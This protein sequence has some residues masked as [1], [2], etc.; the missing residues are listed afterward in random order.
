[1]VE[2]AQQK[3]K[4]RLEAV[5]QQQKDGASPQAAKHLALDQ[6][7][8][9]L[10]VGAADSAEDEELLKVTTSADQQASSKWDWDDM[11]AVRRSN[12]KSYPLWLS[13]YDSDDDEEEEG[14]CDS[15]EEVGEQSV[16]VVEADEGGERK[17]GNSR[18]RAEHGIVRAPEGLKLGGRGHAPPTAAQRGAEKETTEEAK[19]SDA[20]VAAPAPVAGAEEKGVV[21]EGRRREGGPQ[22]EDREHVALRDWMRG[23]ALVDSTTQAESGRPSRTVVTRAL[24][25]HRDVPLDRPRKRREALSRRYTLSPASSSSNSSSSTST[26]SIFPLI[27]PSPPQPFPNAAPG[28]AADTAEGV[29]GTA[30]EAAGTVDGGV[31]GTA[32]EAAGTADG[33]VAGTAGAASPGQAGAS[34]GKATTRSTHSA[35]PLF[36]TPAA[37]PAALP[38]HASSSSSISLSPRAQTYSPTTFAAAAAATGLTADALKQQQQQQQHV[39]MSPEASAAALHSWAQALPMWW[40]HLPYTARMSMCVC[41]CMRLLLLQRV[42]LRVCVNVCACHT[43][44][45]AF[46]TSCAGTLP[47]LRRYAISTA[48]MGSSSANPGSRGRSATSR[49][50]SNSSSSSSSSNTT[51]VRSSRSRSASPSPRSQS[52]SSSANGSANSG[53]GANGSTVG[54]GK[55]AAFGRT[56]S[57]AFAAASVWVHQ[58]ALQRQRQQQQQQEAA[59][60]RAFS[61]RQAQRALQQQLNS[62][63]GKAQAQ[64]ALQQPLSSM[65]GKAPGVGG[66]AEI[67]GSIAAATKAAA[68]LKQSASRW[69]SCG[70]RDSIGMAAMRKLWGAHCCEDCGTHVSVWMAVVRTMGRTT[71]MRMLWGTPCCEDRR[72]RG[73]VRVAG[74]ES[75]VDGLD[76]EHS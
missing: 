58:R 22:V 31:A 65:L 42:P 43:L 3:K 63:L 69:G 46:P 32:G 64:R 70:A 25:D 59:S 13:A 60:A 1:M 12:A 16:R 20:M 40:V 19:K 23:Y 10:A 34:S 48:A 54:G 33:G 9:E 35:L 62:K 27:L 67:K 30:G 2:L 24:V 37:P 52:P 4:Q 71:V 68:V 50:N 17:Q 14:M 36:P 41:V 38:Q 44:M 11:E 51:N 39:H 45:P 7:L 29:A 75:N 66:G 47:P 26:N 72:A 73:S 74:P 57:N 15:D 21:E 76:F 53:S 55:E 49:A 5:L 61:S 28:A 56:G 8:A 18:E 6:G